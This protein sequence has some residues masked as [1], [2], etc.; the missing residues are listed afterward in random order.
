MSPSPIDAFTMA[1]SHHAERLRRADQRR[2]AQEARTTPGKRAAA[3]IEW[4]FSFVRRMR[5][6]RA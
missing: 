3:R 1:Q 2:R 6:S 4:R 5:P